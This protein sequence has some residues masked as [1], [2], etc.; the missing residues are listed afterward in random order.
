MAA[1]ASC[2]QYSHYAMRLLQA[3][4]ELQQCVQTPCLTATVMRQRLQALLTTRADTDDEAALVQAL[5]YLRQEVMLCV[6]QADL[7]GSADLSQVMHAM[8][9]LAEVSLEYSS[10]WLYGELAR[11]QGV[12]LADGVAQ[13]FLVIGMGKL[14]GRELNVSSDIDLVFAYP[15]DGET[16]RGIPNQE[17]FTQLARRLIRLLSEVNEHGF[18]F[19]VDMRLRPNGDAGPLVSSFAALERY[20]Y[21]QGREWERY[22]WIKA[23]VVASACTDPLT[24]QTA[25]RELENLRRPFVF[26]KYL[27]YGAIGAIRELHRQIRAERSRRN[28]AHPTRANDVKLGRGGIRE[29]EF[30]AQLFQLIRGGRVT[31]LQSR[32]TRQT[33]ATELGLGLIEPEVVN[34]LDRAY[35]FLRS[36]E[37]RIQYVDDAQT[38]ALPA[39]PEEL[40]RIAAMMG[41]EQVA[42][43][44]HDLEQVRSRVAQVFDGL[45]DTEAA[46]PQE[47][48]AWFSEVLTTEEG[49]AEAERHLAQQGF[50]EPTDLA[51][52]FSAFV[53]SSRFRS[54]PAQSRQRLDSLISPMLKAAQATPTP[55]RTVQRFLNLLDTIARR[56]A[57]LAL[58]AE[59]PAALRRVAAMLGASPWAATFLTRHPLLLDELIDERAALPM[60]DWNHERQ[61][62]NENLQHAIFA[63]GQPDVERCMDL[64]REFHQLWT[65]RLLAED[66]AGRLSVETLADHLSAL[67]DLLLQVALEQAWAQM[68]TRHREQPQFAIIAYGKLGGKELGYASDLDIIFVYDDEDERAPDVYARLAQRLMNWLTSHTSAGRLF[69]V[70]LRL[71]PNG[72]A[73]LLVS[74]IEALAQYQ[75][76]Q[77]SNAA[78]LWE[79]QALT[80]ARFC[81]GHGATGEKFATVRYQVMTAARDPEPVL[82]EIAQM[83]Q[84]IHDGHP[85]PTPWF[86]LKHDSGGMVDI[87]FIVQAL[88]LLHAQR[89]P[90][91]AANTGTIAL[92][93]LA[94]DEGLLPR[95]VAYASALAYRAYRARQHGLRLQSEA[96]EPPP[97]RVQSNEFVEARAAVQAAWRFVFE[98]VAA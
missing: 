40:E 98:S 82:K 60:P 91:L 8:S 52:S 90:A 65:F 80:R 56:S 4:P 24:S 12:P 62:L 10:R 88:V 15:E 34:D 79:H 57:Y 84:K 50:A 14:G 35:V 30:I 26:R 9:D 19:R 76:G 77:G 41:Y 16:E 37:H 17:F 33:L 61:Q 86:D 53:R 51:R 43:M 72:N 92:L 25:E 96:D 74:S 7:S 42:P 75:L 70:D 11:K 97:A 6:M 66:L 1:V 55:E 54:L 32:P 87:E 39:Q 78:W 49:L 89:L 85:N 69:N 36:L 46:D 31:A 67:A 81:A 44:L 2:W 13:A 29:I 38:H 83:R 64:L 68:L 23:R 21:E 59:H 45:F 94:G 22:A 5:R 47:T 63:S 58:L 95:E 48:P 71:R 20:F 93:R 18:V 28:A 73:G 27:D 3:R